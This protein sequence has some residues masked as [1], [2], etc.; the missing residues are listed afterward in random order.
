MVKRDLASI[1]TGSKIAIVGG[2][3]AGSFFA[4]YLLKYAR[5]KGIHP[6]ITIYE[7]RNFS[8]P[9]PS[10]CKGCAGILSLTAFHNLADLGLTL[11]EEIIQRRIEHYTVHSSQ[12]SITISKPEKDMQI[13]SIYRGGG[14]LLSQGISITGFDGWL[15]QQA[16]MQGVKV[17]N[18]RVESIDIGEKAG[19][20]ISGTISE[21][22]LIVLAS[23]VNSGRIKIGGLEYIPPKTQI[24]S[25]DELYIAAAK[26]D[27]K[28]GNTAYAFLIPH[29]GIIFGTLVPKGSFV[30]VSVLSQ[31]GHS[32][33]VNDFLKLDSVQRMLPESYER[34]C[35]CRPRAAVSTARNYYTDRFV[36]IGD[37]AVSR[38]YKD[39]IGSSLLIAREAAHTVVYHG[40][41]RGDFERYYRP[42]CRSIDR[43]NR[44]G[45]LLFAIN[46]WAKDSRLFLLA[47]YRLIGDEQNNTKGAQP[48]TKAAWGMFTGSY[49]YRNIA[50]M[51][52]NPVSLI[53]FSSA[54][55]QEGVRSLFRH[56]NIS[57]R[58]LHVGGKKV[59]I[60]GSGFGGN[61]VLR[62]LVRTLNRNENV[63][64]T[65]VS[66]ENY[67]LFSPLLH[68][69]AMGRIESSNAAYPL[70]KLHWRDRFNFI[71]ANVEKINLDQ[72]RVFTSRGIYDFDYL[73]LAL[74]S[75]TD[76]SQLDLT[77][78]EKNVFTLKTLND[79]RLIRNHIVG[80]FEQDSIENNPAGK[81]RLLTFVVCGG[82]HIGVQLVTEL[83]DFIYRSLVKF[84]RVSDVSNI[85]IVLVEAEEK[86]VAELHPNLSVHVMNRLKR[87]GI[88]VRLKSRVT[89]ISKEGVEINGTEI[90]PT[91]TIVW[92]AGVVSHPLIA[93]L[94]VERDNIGRVL[95]DEYLA[96]P[97]VP[98]V[99]AVGDCAHFEDLRSG[100]PAPPRAHIAVRQAKVVAYNILSDIRGR[101]RQKYRYSNN[102]EAVSLGSSDAVVRFYGLRLYGFLANI[103]WLIGYSS[104]VTGTPN[105]IRIIMDWLLSSV[106]G[107]DVTFIKPTK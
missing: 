41:S 34:A 12:T 97:Q 24:M 54:W 32:V 94:P 89:R 9:G 61:Y 90:V 77:N 11:P 72:H 49:S 78:E 3:P 17:E 26:K 102:A 95:V 83:R 65:M 39:G 4:L 74:G 86:I 56:Q 20:E 60:L 22:D 16:Q 75:V 43:D 55:S 104:L 70:R 93:A 45:R 29:S 76:T 52:L 21:Y 6:E 50:G 81:R 31:S 87:I 51:T 73:V 37:A 48:F 14:P 8:K 63:E 91:D 80:V 40:R 68:E 46:G 100:Q 28:L 71:Q 59:L 62:H 88:D 84:Y 33:S 35:G 64:I 69:V 36:A 85:R 58:Q 42:F 38:L 13:V 7:P 79:S 92:V 10:G 96:I 98:G 19:I 1:K 103:L 15:L 27:S 2:G 57:P 5:E 30:N 47:Q 105:R 82:G 53:K 44:W 18:K 23:G 66:D 25:Q 107:R 67:F 101:D 106:F 99:Y